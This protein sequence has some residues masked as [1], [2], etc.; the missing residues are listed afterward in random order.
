MAKLPTATNFEV[1]TFGS[2]GSCTANSS[3]TR[4]LSLIVR[5]L[6]RK[7]MSLVFRNQPILEVSAAEMECNFY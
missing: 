5:E 3:L 6:Y 4:L 2:N 1:S 7:F